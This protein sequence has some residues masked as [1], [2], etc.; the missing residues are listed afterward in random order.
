MSFP[1]CSIQVNPRTYKSEVITYCLRS[2][3]YTYKVT[4]S[5]IFFTAEF[6]EAFYQKRQDGLTLKETILAL[7]YDPEVLGE[8]RIDGISHLINKAVREGKGF[9]EG[10]KPRTSI[11]DE[12][13]PDLTRENFL[14]MQHEL[15][16]MRQE[17]EFLR[18][19][20]YTYKVTTSKIFF[21]AEFKEAF[22]QKRQD[23]L[24]LKETILALGYDPEV[25]GEKRIDGIS[26]L[27]NKAVREGKGFTEGIKP[28]TSILDEECPDLTRENFLKMQHE[29]LYM[30]QEL[31]FLKKISSR[32]DI[33]K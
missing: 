6:K 21:T 14:K 28:R 5:K 19:N 11:L 20:R 17:L 27:I 4:T 31:E 29:L 25:L 3:R 7:G 33:R 8:K 1:T 26:H 32:R 30:R 23:G 16:Y 13:C 18:S 12:E 24:T 2:N 10:I 15:L 9:T 22:Y